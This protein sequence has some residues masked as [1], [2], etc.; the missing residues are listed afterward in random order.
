VGSI[1]LENIVDHQFYL[2][3][4]ARNYIRQHPDYTLHSFDNSISVCFNYKDIS[5]KTLCT[6]LYLN[7]EVLVGFGSFREDEFVRLVTIN[8]SLNEQDILNFF[9]RIETFVHRK[10]QMVKA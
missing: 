9:E 2:A 3:D 7:S 1:G 5:A 4:V 8:T 10:K 6:E